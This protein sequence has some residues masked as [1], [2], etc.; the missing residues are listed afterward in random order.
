MEYMAEFLY[1]QMDR[2]PNKRP[3]LAWDQLSP[4]PSK[5]QPGYILDKRLEA[6]QVMGIKQ[7]LQTSVIC[8]QED[9][10]KEALRH[11]GM[12]TK[13]GI[14]YI[15]SSFGMLGQ[16][17]KELVAIKIVRSIKMYREAAMV[18]IDVLQL[19]VVHDMHLI[20]TELKPE[21][22]LFVSPEYITSWPRD[23]SAYRRLLKSS[24]V[25]VIDFCS[26]VCGCRDH[27]YIVST[28]HYRAPE[29]L[30]GAIHAINGVLVASWLTMLGISDDSA[31]TFH[32]LVKQLLDWPEGATSRESIE[33]V[34]KL[35]RLQ[36]ILMQHMDHSAGDLIDLLQGLLQ[37]EASVRMTAH[38][39]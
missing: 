10:L 12:M 8:M 25:K 27:N 16:E 13:M 5:V 37:H 20:H 28:G 36:N 11:G 3:K 38:E 2:R 39:A 35:T 32:L 21:N 7:R 24:A 6:C 19:L 26:A 29:D 31:L 1:S 4:A 17:Q 30:G 15:W 18:E 22:I 23:V 33:G 34:S 9:L 14:M